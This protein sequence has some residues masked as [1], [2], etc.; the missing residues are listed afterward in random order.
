MRAKR[1][2][3]GQRV[4]KADRSPFNVDIRHPHTSL[5]AEPTHVHFPHA[6]SDDV[7]RVYQSSVDSQG[8]QMNLTKAWAWRP[9][10]FEAFAALRAQ[11]TNDSALS[12]RDLAVLVSATAA[13]R[14]DSYCALAWGTTLANQAGPSVASAVL[15]GED[16]GALT[17]RDRALVEWARKVVRDPNG[18][19]AADVDR[20]REAGL[21][22]RE[23]VEATIF[24]AFRLA[25]ST[26]NDALG[27][28][29]DWQLAGAAPKEVA[30]AV[31]FGR[32][33]AGKP[34]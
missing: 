17:E 14:G 34:G 32:A 11:L 4:T 16:P 19:E 18:T 28:N 33:V 31:T 29:P 12:K 24:I 6:E 1:A 13:A 30:E 7:N 2:R 8:F 23:I 26:V 15:K 5:I 25:F 21:A 3:G 10:V 22:E 9:E 20:L 27:I